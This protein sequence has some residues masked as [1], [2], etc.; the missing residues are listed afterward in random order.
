MET[1]EDRLLA[2]LDKIGQAGVTSAEVASTLDATGLADV[3]AEPTE[4]LPPPGSEPTD[5]EGSSE[6]PP[7]APISR[8]N[9]FVHHDTH[10]VVFDVAL[11]GKYQTDWFEWEAETL[12]KEIKEDFHVPSIS[13]HAKTKIQAIKTI[14]I[15]EW[16]WNKWEVFC[17]STQSLNNNIPDFQVMQKATISQ[18]MNAV[19]IATMVRSDEVFVLEV[20]DWVAATVVESGVFYAPAPIAFCQDEIVQLTEELKLDDI[21]Q[22]IKAVE[23]R[24]AEVTALKEPVLQETAVDVQ[25]A[26]LK[27]ACDYL[28]LRRSQ[29]KQQL[30]LLA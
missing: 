13:D 1:H 4:D 15:N 6:A 30:R 22:M 20:Q 26:K 17:W 28:D 29:L 25:V 5:P 18:L 14:H 10:P 7:L 24:F 11:L 27:V 23:A 19:D 12:W 9:F 3:E 8:K 21:P 2:V 16:F